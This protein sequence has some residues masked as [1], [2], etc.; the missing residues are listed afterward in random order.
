MS[1]SGWNSALDCIYVQFS[2]DS[3]FT[4]RMRAERD[5]LG[6]QRLALSA[7]DQEPAVDGPIRLRGRRRGGS[8]R[9]DTLATIQAGML[10]RQAW[11]SGRARPQRRLAMLLLIDLQVQT[12]HPLVGKT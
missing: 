4:R 1:A 8:L 5:R 6:A 2:G 9:G 12:P 7:G 10:L 3:A 11:L